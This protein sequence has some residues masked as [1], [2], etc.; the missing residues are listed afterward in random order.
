MPPFTTV[1]VRSSEKV[2]LHVADVKPPRLRAERPGQGTQLCADC[3]VVSRITPSYQIYGHVISRRT[4]SSQ[5]FDANGPLGQSAQQ[6][7]SDLQDRFRTAV[8]W[9]TAATVLF[10]SPHPKP[11]SLA[12]P[13]TDHSLPSLNVPGQSSDISLRNDRRTPQRC[14]RHGERARAHDGSVIHQQGLRLSVRTRKSPCH[15]QR[16]GKSASVCAIVFRHFLC[17]RNHDRCH[18]SSDFSPGSTEQER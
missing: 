17:N 3:R 13:K 14:Q 8:H 4:R 7:C 15:P 1:I 12:L 18:N 5:M 10:V 6:R 2:G 16:F 11:S 9:G